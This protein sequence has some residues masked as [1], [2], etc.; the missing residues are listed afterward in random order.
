MSNQ[1]RAS[2]RASRARTI[3]WTSA[4]LKGFRQRN[5]GKPLDDSYP[6]SPRD[7]T[8]YEWGRLWHASD[9][10]APYRGAVLAARRAGDITPE[11]ERGLMAAF[12]NGDI[13]RSRR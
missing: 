6:T 11:I 4:F 1:R 5:A 8:L 13:P 2:R 12:G 3:I 10:S 7:R 9:T